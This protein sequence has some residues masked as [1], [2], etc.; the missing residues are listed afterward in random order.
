[1]S[2]GWTGPISTRHSPEIGP[3][4]AHRDDDRG[5]PRVVDLELVPVQAIEPI[6]HLGQDRAL[7]T[8][9]L[10]LG[11]VAEMGQAETGFERREVDEV[12]CLGS[13]KT[14]STL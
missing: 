14:A 12:A 1:V 11:E 3:P 9:V 6:E 10:L 5:E 4:L 2:T 7:E 13:P 8:S